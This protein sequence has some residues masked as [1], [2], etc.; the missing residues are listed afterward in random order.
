M[1]SMLGQI[2]QVKYI[3]SGARSTSDF[4]PD[5]TALFYHMTMI[6]SGSTFE[7][8]ILLISFLNL[9]YFLKDSS[10]FF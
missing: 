8:I 6:D 10:F 1:R 2:T 4:L 5:L 9:N 3:G 7:I